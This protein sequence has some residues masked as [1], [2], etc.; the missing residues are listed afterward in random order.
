M[1]E[2]LRRSH[3]SK[4]SCG[5]SLLRMARSL[6]MAAINRP[7]STV[8]GGTVVHMRAMARLRFPRHSGREHTAREPGIPDRHRF[9]L[10]FGPSGYVPPEWTAKL[11][12]RLH[13][14]RSGLA[15]AD[16]LS[17]S[18]V[19]RPASR[20]VALL[21]RP[22]ACTSPWLCRRR[23]SLLPTSSRN[24]LHYNQQASRRP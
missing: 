6:S 20:G 18:P 5:S 13:P 9:V 17:D 22:L 23:G 14:P 7:G 4:V 3:V 2:R 24:D 21:Q 1:S 12:P 15:V 11:A 19:A 10:D 16:A 8:R